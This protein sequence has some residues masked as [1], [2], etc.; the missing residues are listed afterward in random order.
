MQ[1]LAQALELWKVNTLAKIPGPTVHKVIVDRLSIVDGD[2][3]I[4]W[5]SDFPSS[6]ALIGSVID[7]DCF[8]MRFAA[9]NVHRRIGKDSRPG[10]QGC[11]VVELTLDVFLRISIE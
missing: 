4:R 9:S 7:G 5:P 3:P 8:Y 2:S 6:E 1:A 10:L 11:D